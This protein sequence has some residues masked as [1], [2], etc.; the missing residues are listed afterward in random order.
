M[1][2]G[3]VLDRIG[4]PR[5]GFGKRPSSPITMGVANQITVRV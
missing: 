1:G 5:I 3:V 4:D 2:T